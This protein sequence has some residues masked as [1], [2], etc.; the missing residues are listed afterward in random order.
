MSSAR[1]GPWTEADQ[2]ELDLL[3]Y[4]LVRGVRDHAKRCSECKASGSRIFCARV[5]IA[6]EALCDW[7]RTRQ[8][9]SKAM[10]LATEAVEV[11][12]A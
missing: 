4:T 6:I 10:W 12:H 8:L 3:T 5:E 9:M 11:D 7:T 1:Y 2:A